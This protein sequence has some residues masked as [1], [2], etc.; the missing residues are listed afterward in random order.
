[1]DWL[2]GESERVTDW[3]MGELEKEMVKEKLSHGP[4]KE[5]E[6]DWSSH[7]LPEKER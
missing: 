2:R 6:M 7:E 1:M 5:K 4:G 3:S